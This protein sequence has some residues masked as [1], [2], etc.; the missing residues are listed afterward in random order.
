[1]TSSQNPGSQNIKEKYNFS[2]FTRENYR[3][4]LILAKQ[5]YKFCSYEN[6]ENEDN[7]I[8][9]RHDLDFSVH[10]AYAVSEIEKNLNIS[11]VYFLHLHNEF[12]NLLEKEIF[13]LVLK[14]IAGGHKIGIHFDTHFYNIQTEND[15]IKN[16]LFEKNI[17]ENVFKTD[18]NVFSF[19]NTND[20]ILTFDKHTYGGLINA[21]SKIFQNDIAYISDSNGYWR[22]ERLEDVI[23]QHKYNK[24]QILTH[25]AW[26]Q[27]EVLSPKKRIWRCIEGRAEKTK[28]KYISLLKNY[29]RENIDDE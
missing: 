28:S 15:L 17:L 16:L 19:H 18:I 1:M 29:G 27:D 25:P 26:W 10:S 12:Y 13:E 11:A 24:L 20:K 5:F 21:Y 8:I 9:L 2:D 6:F 23:K 3:N 22:F 7:F 4:I 14:I